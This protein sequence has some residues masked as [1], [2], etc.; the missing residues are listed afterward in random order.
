MVTQTG[1]F[2]QEKRSVMRLHLQTNTALI[3][4][5]CFLSLIALPALAAPSAIYNLGTLGG[6]FSE[7]FA[8][9]GVGQVAGVSSTAGDTEEHA[10][11]YTGT[12]GSGG[13]MADLGALPGGNISQG[14]GINAGGQVAGYSSSGIY[15]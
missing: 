12:P 4:I 6:L 5:V 2:Y 8:V 9:N 13:V 15:N 10:F 14:Y 1:G 3:A 11:L 7:S